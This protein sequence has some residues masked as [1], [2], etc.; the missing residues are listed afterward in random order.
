[1]SR[2]P[3]LVACPIALHPDGHPPRI[4]VFEHPQAGFQLVKGGMKDGEHPQT[5][6]ARELIEESGL[7]TRS[8]IFVGTADDIQDGAIW[9]FSLCRV[10]P[11]VRD[12]WAHFCADDGGHRF[13]FRWLELDQAP[14]APFHPNFHRALAWI[15]QNL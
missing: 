6:A 11:P 5:A 2:A 3:R 12:R 10:A 8:A 14:P 9:H 15:R 1:M 13:E 4:P 7:E